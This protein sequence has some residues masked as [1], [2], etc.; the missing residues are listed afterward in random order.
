VAALVQLYHAGD[1][2]W[3]RTASLTLGAPW[4][5]VKLEFARHLRDRIA[6]GPDYY[7][8]I[9]VEL[10]NNLARLSDL[11]STLRGRIVASP[12]CEAR[13][14]AL[15]VERAYRKMWRNWCET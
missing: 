7:V 14:F 1:R 10:A 11:R 4:I 8:L 5:C 13:V 12:L 6:D 3:F 2:G 15:A 9:A